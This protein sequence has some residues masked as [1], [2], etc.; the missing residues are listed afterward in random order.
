MNIYIEIEVFDREFKSRLLL[1][2]YA[3]YKNFDVYLM[4]RS[5]I[6][7]LALGDKISPGII[8]M[9]DANS[10]NEIYKII[11]SLKKKGFVFIAQDEEAGILYDDYND[12]V[13]RRFA[14]GKSFGLLEYFFCWGKR[15]YKILSK[16]FKNKTKFINIGSPR[17][18]LL[19]KEF[20][21]KKNIKN[22]Y[23]KFHLNK[24]ILIASNISWP[25][26]FRRIP[27]A[28]FGVMSDTK[29][30]LEWKEDFFFNVN[31][32]QLTM[33]KYYIRLIRYL[34]KYQ[35]KYS[36]VLRPHP[37]ERVEDWK[38]MIGSKDK[39]LRVIKE[40]NLSEF[41]FNSE[42]I[43]QNG[44]TSS[45]ESKILGKK[46]ISFEPVKFKINYGRKLPN[47]LGKICKNNHE[48]LKVIKNINKENF[49][50][51]KK[52]IYD[53]QN[54]LNFNDK[55]LSSIKI[56]SIFNILRNRVK[57]NNKYFNYKKNSFKQ[58]IKT[59][60]KKSIYKVIKLKNQPS[61]FEEKFPIL[62]IS[63]LEAHK[64]EFE[65]FDKKLKSIRYKIISDRVLKIYNLN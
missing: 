37:T 28:Y 4:H 45:I 2:S 14:D 22:F 46:T 13:K 39:K 6:H 11:K 36:I 65:I 43:I 25:I 7:D 38:K 31:I 9:K 15:D 40:H 23:K 35:N 64:K 10:T 30:N 44:C 52:F 42:I 33:L 58:K 48:V 41:I 63:E 54:R 56:V 3:A 1:A 16:K 19:K 59:F 53:L 8:F 34:L 32:Q 24:Y 57:N 21:K 62:K 60:I 29:N 20:Y 17:I 12:F 27:D 47:K 55:I 5:E 18:D 50:T 49:K 26:G 61:T 51:N